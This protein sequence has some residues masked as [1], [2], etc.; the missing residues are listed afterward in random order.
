MQPTTSLSY[1]LQGEGSF[2]RITQCQVAMPEG[3]HRVMLTISTKG[4]PVSCLRKPR[5]E[6][7][8]LNIRKE[9]LMY[10]MN[11]SVE[12]IEGSKIGSFTEMEGS[13]VEEIRT[14]TQ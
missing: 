8:D 4:C 12:E 10:I 14:Q 1:V 7:I 11:I 2:G 5:V 6:G 9:R 13:A 3:Q